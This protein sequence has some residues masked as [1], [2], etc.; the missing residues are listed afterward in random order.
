MIE[1][2]KNNPLSIIV[3]IIITFALF[4]AIGAITAVV[5]QETIIVEG[6]VVNAV[7]QRNY[8]VLEM[9]DGNFYKI[10]FPGDNI[11]LTVNSKIVMRLTS[12]GPFYFFKDDIYDEVSIIKVP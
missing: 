12:Y 6:K 2:I 4:I 3:F 11:D 1:I 10:R 7:V 8:I 9:D 5:F